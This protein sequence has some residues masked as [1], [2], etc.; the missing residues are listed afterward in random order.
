MT[1]VGAYCDVCPGDDTVYTCEGNSLS[2]S[3]VRWDISNAE[4]PHCFVQP[5]AMQPCGPNG[6]F[7]PSLNWSGPNFTSSLRANKVP[8]SLNG[9]R[10]ECVDPLLDSVIIES[11]NICIVGK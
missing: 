3:I 1:L 11:Y 8:L 9:T 7:A 5:N 10:L 4:T 2:S 6:I